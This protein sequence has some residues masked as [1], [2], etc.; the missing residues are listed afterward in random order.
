MH[1]YEDSVQA[2]VTTQVGGFAFVPTWVL[3]LDMTDAHF[4]VYVALRS[5]ADAQGDCFPFQSTIA[6][7]AK[8]STKTV[9]KAVAHFRKLGIVETRERYRPD[10]SLAGLIYHLIDILPQHLA[11]QMTQG[12]D[13]S[14]AKQSE[15]TPPSPQ[16]GAPLPTEGARENNTKRTHQE[17]T[18]D[19]DASVVART[20]AERATRLPQSWAVSPEMRDWARRMVPLV[21]LGYEDQKFQDYWRGKSGQGA[22]KRD[23]M[24]TWRNWMRRADEE[25]QRRGGNRAAN[26]MTPKDMRVANILAMGQSVAARHEQHPPHRQPPQRRFPDESQRRA[27]E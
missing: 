15:L 26:G 2:R 11:A 1:G 17:K 9:E 7:R 8:C 4:R 12:D 25:L 14:G 20:R 22:T 18:T 24:A 5:F 3:L 6:G 21:D 10:G 16:R 27:L 13:V 19:A 23:W